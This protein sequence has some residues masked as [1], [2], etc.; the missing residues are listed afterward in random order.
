MRLAKCALLIL[1]LFFLP[2]CA[3]KVKP[4]YSDFPATQGPTPSQE[5]V[6]QSGDLLDI[7]FFYNPELN[8]SV[9]VRPDG[10]ISL[11]LAREV[12]AS[13]T[14]PAQ[15]TELLANHYAS[16][17]KNPEITIIVRSFNSQKVYVDGEVNRAG[18]VPLT[19]PMTVLQ[20]ISQAGGMKDTAEP[21]EVLVV[22]KICR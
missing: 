19:D 16:M 15:L 10:R 21:T 14:T 1:V 2:A 8:E 3:S 9:T 20:A 6:I 22:R 4:V 5:Y 13:G 7:K 11:Q 18:M 17:I 12:K